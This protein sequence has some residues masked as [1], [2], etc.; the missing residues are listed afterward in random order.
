MSGSKSSSS[1]PLLGDL[2]SG[3]SNSLSFLSKDG[4]NPLATAQKYISSLKAPAKIMNEA[5]IKSDLV[6]V[7]GKTKVKTT[8]DAALM[9]AVS[10]RR[11]MNNNIVDPLTAT[12][13]KAVAAGRSRSSLLLL[14]VGSVGK[15][16]SVGGA[17]FGGGGSENGNGNSLQG[18]TA[19]VAAAAAAAAA[20]AMVDLS[21]GTRGSVQRQTTVVD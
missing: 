19:Y 3:F 21:G 1:I 15:G 10:K 16:G 12:A 13:A 4:A 5:L 2:E 8:A 18:S 14:R 6:H 17:S 20:A 11:S 7:K 9:N